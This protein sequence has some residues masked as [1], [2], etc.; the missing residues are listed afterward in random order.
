MAP[1]G[2]AIATPSGI[3]FST[4]RAI[5]TAGWVG[6]LDEKQADPQLMPQ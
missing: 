3:D 2:I 4:R 6:E 5:L 1:E